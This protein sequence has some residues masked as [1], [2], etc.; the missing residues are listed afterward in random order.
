LIKWIIFTD[1][2]G[3]LNAH[4]YIRSSNFSASLDKTNYFNI[5]F[6]I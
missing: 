2:H 6:L 1:K 5:F 4:A 3:S